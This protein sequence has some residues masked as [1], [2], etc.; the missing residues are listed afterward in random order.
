LQ[1][2]EARFVVGRDD[3]VEDFDIEIH[4][5]DD[6]GNDSDDLLHPIIDSASDGG[7]GPSEA[8]RSFLRKSKPHR[9]APP[10]TAYDKSHVSKT[11]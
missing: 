5:D 4:N 9:S 6:D 8:V 10:P 1:S 11:F 2:G 7:T 3:E